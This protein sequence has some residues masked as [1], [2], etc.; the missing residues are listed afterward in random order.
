M[1]Q[2]QGSHGGAAPFGTPLTSFV[3]QYG[4]PPNAPVAGFA[5][6]RRPHFWHTPHE[7]RGPIGSSIE[8]PSGRNRMRDRAHFGTPLT[9]IV[10]S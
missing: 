3:A 1:P 10:A 7:D 9:R 6:W 8:G 5:W 4:A 2:W